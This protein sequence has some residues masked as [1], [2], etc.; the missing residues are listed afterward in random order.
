MSFEMGLYVKRDFCMLMLGA[1]FLRCWRICVVCLA[2]ELIG[3]WV[4][5]AF[6]V[7]MEAFEWSLII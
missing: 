6:T 1:M 4:V 3:S 5:V 7:G 2:L